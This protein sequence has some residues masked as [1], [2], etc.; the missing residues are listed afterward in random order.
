MLLAIGSASATYLT[1]RP[2]NHRPIPAAISFATGLLNGELAHWQLLIQIPLACYILYAFN[3]HPAAISIAGLLFAASWLA[4]VFYFLRALNSGEH[5]HRQLQNT[6]GEHYL[7]SSNLSLSADL[8]KQPAF[9]R[10]LRPFSPRRDKVNVHRNICIDSENGFD[11]LIDIYQ[12]QTQESAGPVLYQIHGGAWTTG[13]GDRTQQALPLMNHLAEQGWVCVTIDYRLSPQHRWPAH[14]IDCKKGLAWIK[15]NIAQYGGDPNFIMAT[16]GSA[17]GHLCSLLALTANDPAYQPGFEDADT[18]VQACI[19]FYA[20]LDCADRYQQQH[21][22]AVPYYLES[23]VM[24]QSYSV[25]PHLFNAASPMQ[26]VN[27]DAP[28]FLIIHGS[29]DSLASCAEAI[30]FSGHLRK[31]SQAP[32]IYLEIEYAQHAFELFHSPHSDWT[33]IACARFGNHLYNLHNK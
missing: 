29:H 13:Y 19:P 2:I 9:K 1:F 23:T 18:Q 14:I 21:N 32:V 11:L 26:R 28:P 33:A 5:I 24:Q 10:W 17:G 8:N 30:E 20:V 27:A 6:L 12:R 25:D 7:A 4:L 16:G 22:I 15:Q 31:T 3:I